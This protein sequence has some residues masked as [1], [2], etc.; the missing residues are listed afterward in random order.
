VIRVSEVVLAGHPDKLCD[1]IADAVVGACARAGADAYAQIEVGIWSEHLWMSGATCT[2]APL[3]RS[4]EVIA[5][6]VLRQVG[7]PALAER[8]Q[9]QSTVCQHV[10][11]PRRWTSSVNDQAIVVGWA[12]YDERTRWLPPEQFLA[13][14]LREAVGAAFGQGPL[15][16]CGPD[17]KLLVR[18]CEDDDGFRLEHLLATVQEREGSDHLAFCADLA[19]VLR[20]AYERLQRLDPRWL[21]IW[22]DVALLLNPNGLFVDGG[23]AGDNGQ[24]GRKLA[25]DFYGPRVPL[26]GGALS[27]KHLAHI[28]RVGSYAAREAAI[29]AV[30]SGASE[31]LVRVCWAPN[32][33]LP[34][35]VTYEMTGRGVRQGAAWFRHEAMVARYRD[36]LDYGSLALGTHFFGPEQWN[37]VQREGQGGLDGTE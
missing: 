22:D 17:G 20:E 12:G 27:G 29:C 14:A 23:A 10:G 13:H 18:I 32:V 6:D 7:Y 16:G 28:D 3:D 24:T 37:Q 21:A 19:R 15:E 33:P 11:D 25:M 34:L 35:D 2:P 26:G 30:A 5:R 4:L 8:I 9:I 31:C 36:P 1:Q